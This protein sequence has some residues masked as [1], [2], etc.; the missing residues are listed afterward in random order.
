MQ[1]LSIARE[2]QVRRAVSVLQSSWRGFLARR[3]FARMLAV[4]AAVNE[5]R[6]VASIQ[7]QRMWRGWLGRRVRGLYDTHPS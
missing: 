7:I 5:A 1:H 6:R 4:I 2:K 3:D